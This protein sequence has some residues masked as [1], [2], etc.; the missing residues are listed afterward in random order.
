MDV[1]TH[2]RKSSHADQCVGRRSAGLGRPILLELSLDV[3]FPSALLEH[4][5]ALS[6]PFAVCYGK[7]ESGF[8]MCSRADADPH[9]LDNALIVTQ[10]FGA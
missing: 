2:V 9:L 8:S 7:D 6:S 10:A 5:Q 3:L 1:L 4:G